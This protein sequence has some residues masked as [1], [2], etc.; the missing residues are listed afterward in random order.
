MHKS[1]IK[2]KHKN[3]KFIYIRSRNKFLCQ[4]KRITYTV[5]VFPFQRQPQKMFFQVAYCKIISEKTSQGSQ[6]NNWNRVL[7]LVKLQVR[8]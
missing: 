2:H 5:A 4:E 6:E 8:T 3:H 7:F 1:K